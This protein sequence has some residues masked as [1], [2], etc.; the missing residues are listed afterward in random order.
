MIRNAASSLYA[1]ATWPFRLPRAAEWMF[2]ARSSRGRSIKKSL[3]IVGTVLPLGS[4]IWILLFWHS[5][6]MTKRGAMDTP[7]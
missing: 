7:I 6:A 4:L 1:Y 2:A 3:F 5:N